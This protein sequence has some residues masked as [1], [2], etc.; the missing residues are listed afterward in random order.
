M[1]KSGQLVAQSLTLYLTADIV[2]AGRGKHLQQEQAQPI[3]DLRQRQRR[4][5][6]LT[7][8]GFTDQELHRHQRQRHVVMPPLPGA[9]LILVHADLAFASFEAR[10]NTGAR[11]DDP[12]QFPKRRLLA[13]HLAPIRWREVIE[14]FLNKE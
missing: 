10:F 14:L 12:R 3:A 8:M 5:H 4:C 9:D 13:R 2:Y 6:L 1:V 7:P 11:L